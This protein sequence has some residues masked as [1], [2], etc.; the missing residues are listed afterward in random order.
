LKK[1]PSAPSLGALQMRIMERLWAHGPQAL[2][3]LHRSLAEES[4]IAYTTISTELKRLQ[5]KGLV[6]KRGVHL[7][8][9]YAPVIG[10]ETFV[11]RL[12]G[13]VFQGLLGT[14]GQ[15]AIHGFV[16]AIAHDPEA[17]EE[18]LRLLQERR[19]PP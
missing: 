14:H 9:R 19:S 8:T 17:L 7:E 13:G 5:Q 3:E 10:R 12:V 2:A 4:N 16:E 11:E 18:T 15:A 1:K 6:T